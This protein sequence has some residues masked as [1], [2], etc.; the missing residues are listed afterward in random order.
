MPARAHTPEP[1]LWEGAPQGLSTALPRHSAPLGLLCPKPQPWHL[2]PSLPAQPSSV[3]PAHTMAWLWLS[4]VLAP[5]SALLP[6]NQGKPGR[7]NI[8][9]LGSLRGSAY[10]CS[11][12]ME[13]VWVPKRLYEVCGLLPGTPTPPRGHSQTWT[14]ADGL[15]TLG[16][17]SSGTQLHRSPTCGIDGIIQFPTSHWKTWLSAALC[18]HP[19]PT[20]KS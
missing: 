14:E 8:C 12:Y 16:A 10:R 9:A 20:L 18:P 6:T 13:V 2:V 5:V 15:R 11:V 3:G 19:V 1:S 17:G 7:R 4:V